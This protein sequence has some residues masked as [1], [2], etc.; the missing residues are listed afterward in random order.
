MARVP[1]T[2]LMRYATIATI[3]AAVFAAIALTASAAPARVAGSLSPFDS[4]LLGAI[5]ATRAA[6]GAPPLH[7]STALTRAADLHSAEMTRVGYFGHA[8]ANGGGF[9]ARIGRF[10]RAHGWRYWS[11]GENLVAGSPDLD[12][13]EAIQTWM[14]SPVHR[15]TLLG[16]AWREIGISAVH[17]DSSPGVFG[18]QPVTVVTVDFGVRH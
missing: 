12:V 4:S 9:D 1:T 11:V 13:G 10:Y 3:A 2:L 17:A 5:N 15:R 16:R 14:D 8:S 7:L 18:G 6:H